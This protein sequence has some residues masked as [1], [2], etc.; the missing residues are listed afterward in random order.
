MM[1]NLPTAGRGIAVNLKR[2]VRDSFGAF[3]SSCIVMACRIR[4]K[5]E[6]EILH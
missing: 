3:S 2:G 5:K 4:R 1:K 6:K